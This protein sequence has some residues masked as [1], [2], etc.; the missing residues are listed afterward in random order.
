M[1]PAFF[2]QYKAGRFRGIEEFAAGS[3]KTQ[4]RQE[5]QFAR[6]RADFAKAC[7]G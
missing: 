1:H 5:N 3:L 6:R 2:T 7:G 4:R